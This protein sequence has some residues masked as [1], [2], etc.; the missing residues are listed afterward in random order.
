MDESK[1]SALRSPRLFADYDH[2]NSPAD[3]VKLFRDSLNNSFPDFYVQLD[4]INKLYQCALGQGLPFKCQKL[5]AC[6]AQDSGKTTWMYILR[7]KNNTECH[8]ARE[9][10][11]F[12]YIFRENHS[13]CDLG[14]FPRRFIATISKEN[15][16]S[17]SQINEDTL[18][19]YI[20]EW[21]NNFL[22][23]D[24]LKRLLQGENIY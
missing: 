23:E 18:L 8:F 5:L 21:S 20:D 7:G 24:I 16:F 15:Q 3:N 17:F 4:F 6:G 11:F 14:L 19:V 9:K 2:L 13:S 12:F 10:T 22:D 1:Y